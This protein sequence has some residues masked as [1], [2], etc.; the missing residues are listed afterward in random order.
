MDKK[1]IVIV[2]LVILLILSVGLNLFLLNFL[3]EST[4]E[5]SCDIQTNAFFN[6]ELEKFSNALENTSSNRIESKLE[7]GYAPP[8]SSNTIIALGWNNS[9]CEDY[10]TIDIVKKVNLID[11]V[12]Q[13]SAKCGI[14]SEKCFTTLIYSPDVPNGFHE[15][16]I[17]LPTYTS[18]MPKESC[19]LVEGYS[20]I[21]PLQDI[22]FGDYIFKNIAQKGD[23]YPKMCIYYKP[24]E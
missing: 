17:Q 24:F 10:L 4:I 19:E 22:P 18:F 14:P 23:T 1:K 9:Q 5:A 2:I 20:I 6:G 3:S 15:Q 12:K 13:C 8:A 7:F 11:N 21:D 16:C